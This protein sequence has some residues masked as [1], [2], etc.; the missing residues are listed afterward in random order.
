[1]W[2]D[3]AGGSRDRNYLDLFEHWLEDSE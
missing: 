1:V 3:Y 2:P